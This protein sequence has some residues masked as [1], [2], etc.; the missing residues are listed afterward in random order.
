[1]AGLPADVVRSYLSGTAAKAYDIDLA[2]LAP[3]AERIGPTFGELMEPY[4]SFPE[5]ALSSTCAFR[6]VGFLA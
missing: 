3:V 5:D 4:T 2:K 6:D 1:M